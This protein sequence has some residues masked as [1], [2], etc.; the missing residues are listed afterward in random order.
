VFLDGIPLAFFSCQLR[1]NVVHK[2]FYAEFGNLHVKISRDAK[3]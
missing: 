3:A 2:G 1:H